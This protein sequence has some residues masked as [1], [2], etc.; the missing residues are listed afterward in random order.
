MV[1]TRIVSL[2]ASSTEILCALGVEDQLVGRSHEC[3]YP[4]S[5]ARLPTVTEIKLDPSQPSGQIDLTVKQIIEK[6]LSIYEVDPNL[7]SELNPD[8]IIT[9][10]P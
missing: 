9:P 2:L 10:G 6:G 1:D 3:D 5:V 8:I 7:L 4:P